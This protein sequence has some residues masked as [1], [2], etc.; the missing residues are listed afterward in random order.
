L[1]P[2]EWRTM[3]ATWIWCIAKTMPLAPQRRPSAKQESATSAIPSPPPPY[4]VGTSADNALASFS[5]SM[6]SLGKRAFWSTSSA[7]AAEISSAMRSTDATRLCS[8]SFVV[9]MS[10]THSQGSQR[11]CNR[12]DALECVARKHLVRK[13]DVELLLEREHHVHARVRRHAGGIQIRLVFE[14]SRRDGQPAVVVQH[15][16]DAFLHRVAT[17]IAAA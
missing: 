15:A 6:V 8:F 1:D 4:R 12:I 3:H 5:A 9:V 7:W 14:N 16:A 11:R 2:A 10:S 17:T 13:L